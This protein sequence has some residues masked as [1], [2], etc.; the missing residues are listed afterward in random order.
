MST[1]L[2]AGI[3]PLRPMQ[4][5]PDSARSPQPGARSV[6][7]CFSGGGSRAL[8]CAMGQLRGLRHLGLLDDAFAISSVSGGTWANALFTYL[9]ASISDDNFLGDVELDPSRLTISRLDELPANNLGWVPTRFDPARIVENLYRLKED[10]GYANSELWQGFIGEQVLQDYGLWSPS[11]DGFDPR[12]FSWTESYLNAPNGILAQNP[13]L[14][15]GDF[16]TVQRKRPYPVFNTSLFNSDGVD[17]ELM[18]FE[19]NFML[20]VRAAFPKSAQQPG[21]IGG[22]LVDSFAMRSTYLGEGD[23]GDVHTSRPQRAFSLSDIA[24]CSS[25]AFAQMFEEQYPELKGLVPRYNYWPIKGRAE[26]PPLDYRFAD[27]GSLENLGINALL[28]RGLPRLIV[29]INTDEGVRR[30]PAR[31]D[32]VVSSDLPPLFGLQPFSPAHGYVPYGPYDPG[33]GAARLFR[34]NQVFETSAFEELK[35]N[36]LA[37]KRAGGAMLV[38]QTLRVL[39]NPWFNVPAQEAVEVLWV[40]NDNVSS[41]WSQ[42]PTETRI[43]LDLESLDDF[44]LY[45]TFTQLYLTP[46]MVNALAHLACWQVASSSTLG[47]QGGMSNAEVVRGVFG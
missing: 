3:L 14:R 13:T 45:N 40:Y 21:D 34:H 22:G 15:A 42:L 12:Y 23:P 31:Q 25:A 35:Q 33:T 4:R 5:A 27:G 36:L 39:N 18:P 1:P 41:W 16:I 37:A 8:S 6:G 44:P 46:V 26:Q 38:R 17:A 32:T 11:N 10:Y 43:W 20:G 24:G 19:A 29:F 9:P 30:D 7:L 28:A 2:T 47:N